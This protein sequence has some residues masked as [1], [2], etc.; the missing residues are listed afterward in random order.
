MTPLE[1]VAKISAFSYDGQK[2][3]AAREA[4]LNQFPLSSIPHLTKDMYRNTGSKSTFC[5]NLE[6]VKELPFGIGGG[7]NDKFGKDTNARFP[8][9][10]GI[11]D[12]IIDAENGITG[13]LQEKHHLNDV[14]VIVLIKILAIYLPDKFLTIGQRY[15]LELLAR[16]LGINQDQRDL[17]ELNYRCNQKLIQLNPT[18][19]SYQFNQLGAAVWNYLSPALKPD[20]NDWLKANMAP[21]SG[22][23]NAY[24]N[25]LERLSFFYKENY[26]YS[27][28][29][30]K[31]LDVLYDETVLH[32]KDNGGKYYFP[33]PSYGNKL[34]YSASVKSYKEFVISLG[35][36]IPASFSG[37]SSTKGSSPQVHY[38]KNLILYGPP[39][40]GKTYNT[41]R[42]AVSII[43]G[44]DIKTFTN[45]NTYPDKDGNLVDVKNAFDSLLEAER[46][47]F[48]TFHQSLSYEDFIEG[49]KPEPTEAKDNVLYD[50]HSG[51][52]KL[53]CEKASE[54]PDDKYVLV[55]DEIN[56]GNVAS[57]F[58]ELITL[59]EDD[60]RSGEPNYIQCVLPYSKKRFSVPRNLYIIG[61]MNTADRSV[62]A[63]DS[64]LRRRFDFV[65]MMPDPNK[66]VHRKDVF[67]TINNRLRILKDAEHQLGHSYF[68]GI[69]SDEELCTV[70]HNKVIPLIQEYFYGDMEKIRLVI[71][72]GFCVKETVPDA[73]FPNN[74]TD[75]DIPTETWRL[76]D[77]G[78]WQE[79]KSDIT[80][81]TAALDRLMNG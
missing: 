55:I 54:H 30:I 58:G 72:D 79:C 40:T 23:V 5:Y 16:I 18:F 65:E 24:V 80:V 12:M 35:S 1:L 51:I 52:L 46:I 48:T 22:A 20:F 74:T 45:S 32:Q 14:S 29:Q 77:E 59:I 13:G 61:T 43:E 44:I 26:F 81:F 39:G 78:K 36:T 56:R 11:Y 9:V 27:G 34:F 37:D 76:W 66:V 67:E 8:N 68:I 2:A 53:I 69:K 31:E 62:E 75:I 60:K 3:E 64:A 19:S 49:I 42:Y 57:I 73:L 25:S 10:Q 50:V 33:R 17:I 70:F 63:L 7:N 6:F 47:F 28:I 71:G 21:G 15:T 4:F 41:I 38:P